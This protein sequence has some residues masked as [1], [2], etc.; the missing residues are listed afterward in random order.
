M[1]S[2]SRAGPD[3]DQSRV[4]A[5]LWLAGSVE[6]VVAMIVVE[7]G[8]GCGNIGG[9]YNPLTDPISNLGS[10]GFA[11]N[12]SYYVSNGMQIPWPT[13]PLWPLF[14]FSIMVLGA[15]LVAGV[16]RLTNAFSSSPWA[17]VSLG[18]FV[19]AGFGGAGVGIVAED[20]IL[21]LHSLFALVAFGGAGIAV[22]LMGF[23]LADDRRWG[24][25]WAIYTLASGVFSLA[26][27]VVFNFPAMGL[28]PT[29]AVSGSG[30]GYG[31]MERLI[32]GAPILW[33]ILA[34]LHIL[35]WP[36]P[37]R[38]GARPVGEPT[39]GAVSPPA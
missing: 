38:A 2:G 21:S 8:Y 4:G 20:A 34:S 27:T 33:L 16:F 25:G 23:A 6:F 7:L 10:A 29:W 12:P 26:A 37:T 19:L 24:R 30:F 15:L 17:R 9:C 18:V 11:G 14:N 3:E 31:G 5:A 13:S 36:E 35:R 39:S 32:I 22:L 1:P 28:L